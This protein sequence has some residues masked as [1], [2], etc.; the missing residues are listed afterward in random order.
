MKRRTNQGKFL[1]SQR[2]MEEWIWK[3]RCRN[4]ND[5]LEALRRKLLSC[6]NYD[7]VI[8][9]SPML[10]RYYYEVVRLLHKWLNRRSQRRPMTRAPARLGASAAAGG[11]QP[12]TAGL[13]TAGK[14]A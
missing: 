8:G 9:N 1:G 4:L 3:V 11:K 7:G 12:L 5:L 2:A 6:R 10:S 14:P 13:Q